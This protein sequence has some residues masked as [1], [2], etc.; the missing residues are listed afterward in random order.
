MMQL[1]KGIAYSGE[2]FDPVPALLIHPIVLWNPQRTDPRTPI[3]KIQGF[4]Q[5]MGNSVQNSLRY[6]GQTFAK[7]RTVANMDTFSY[8]HGFEQYLSETGRN[9]DIDIY[10]MQN[11]TEYLNLILSTNKVK[12]H[13]SYLVAD[14]DIILDYLETTGRIGICGIG[15]PRK[16]QRDFRHII[17]VVGITADR[18]GIV[19]ID[20]YGYYPYAQRFG[21]CVV[22]S[23][24]W[25]KKFST[26][27]TLLLENPQ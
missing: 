2:N 11:H 3:R 25:L 1:K 20:P 13:A 18:N 24:E 16:G 10:V 8:Y 15:V 4:Q 9:S 7:L 14:V 6:L 22:Y 19:A 12:I 26:H 5:C 21:Y 27:M 17:N 23:I